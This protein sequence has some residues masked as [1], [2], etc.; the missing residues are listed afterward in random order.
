[1]ATE[2]DEKEYFLLVMKMVELLNMKMIF[3]PY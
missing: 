1:M 2:E 3:K